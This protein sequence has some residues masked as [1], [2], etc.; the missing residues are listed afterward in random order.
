VVLVVEDP[1]ATAVVLMD[2]LTNY[3]L[4]R[5]VEDPVPYGVDGD[6][7]VAAWSRLVL[8]MRPAAV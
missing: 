6:R 5:E 4:Q 2:A 7:F 8:G 3:W 1:E